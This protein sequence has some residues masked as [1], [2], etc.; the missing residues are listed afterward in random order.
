MFAC[1]ACSRARGITE[2][3][4]ATWN[5]K[6]GN[7]TIFCRLGGVVRPRDVRIAPKYVSNIATA[8]GSSDKF[9]PACSVAISIR[10]ASCCSH[11]SRRRC[12]PPAQSSAQ[13]SAPHAEAVPGDPASAYDQAIDIPPDPAA[14]TS[15]AAPDLPKGWTNW[16]LYDGKFLSYKLGFVPILDYDAFSQDANSIEQSGRQRDQWDLRSMRFTVSGRL[17]FP[18]PVTYLLGD[19]R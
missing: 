8:H 14:P 15:Y 2:A 1:G 13:S 6:Y 16:T 10:S 19:L 3:D 7:P 12:S 4:L 11:C 9:L 17:K 18:I 5:A